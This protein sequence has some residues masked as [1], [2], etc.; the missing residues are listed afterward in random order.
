MKK[1][2]F[3]FALFGLILTSFAFTFAFFSSPKV[4][5]LNIETKVPHFINN[6]K[7]LVY[8]VQSVQFDLD[9]GKLISNV[10]FTWNG[11]EPPTEIFM[12][13]EVTVFDQNKNFNFFIFDRLDKPFKNGNKVI[14]AFETTAVRYVGD[15]KN[16]LYASFGFSGDAMPKE[17][18]SGLT[19]VLFVHGKKS[20]IKK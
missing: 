9:S 17:T 13:A 15:E 10:E 16:N 7:L 5:Y 12:N 2:I 8:K 18:D 14:A 11:I 6:Q 19:P 4:E 3:G 1:H 20:I